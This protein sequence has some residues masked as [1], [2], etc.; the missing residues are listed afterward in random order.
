MHV[1]FPVVSLFVL[2]KIME[3]RIF[4]AHVFLI[5]SALTQVGEGVLTKAL[6][7]AFHI[8]ST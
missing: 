8:P 2:K 1:C 6:Y 3:S 4:T 7:E 5:D